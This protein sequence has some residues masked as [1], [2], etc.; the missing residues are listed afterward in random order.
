MTALGIGPAEAERSII[1]VARLKLR[2]HLVASVLQGKWVFSA[3]LEVGGLLRTSTR[4]TLDRRT[5]SACVY[6]HL[7]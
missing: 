5:E 7:T 4:P 1:E 6:A 2:Y 3:Q